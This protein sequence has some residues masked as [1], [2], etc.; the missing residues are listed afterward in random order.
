MNI[1]YRMSTTWFDNKIA[2]IELIKS[3][4]NCNTRDMLQAMGVFSLMAGRVC[5]DRDEFTN[6]GGKFKVDN[7][8]MVN[9]DKYTLSSSENAMSRLFS[10]GLSN[11]DIEQVVITSVVVNPP[12]KKVV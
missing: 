4:G 11:G 12:L 9:G 6:D 2:E 5:F 1:K 7:M 3:T 8:T 10:D